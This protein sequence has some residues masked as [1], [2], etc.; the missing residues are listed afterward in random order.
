MMNELQTYM[1]YEYVA[2]YRAGYLS[3]RDLVRRVLNI[4]GGVGS[5]ATLLLTLGCS[6]QPAAPTSAPAA[7]TTAPTK[8]AAASP[9]PS[10]VGASSPAARPAATAPSPSAAAKPA[11][12]PAP[13]A[14]ASP[15][16]VARSPLAVTANDPTVDGQDISF[17]GADGATILAYQA[18][19][20][21]ASGPLPLVLVCHENRGLTEHI[22]DVVR[23]FTKEGYLASGVDLVSRQ[24]GTAR[25]TDP[26]QFSALLTGPNVNPDQFVSDFASA[27]AY[28]KTR[29]DL[30]QFDKI[31][32]N[33]YC[34]GGGVVWRSTE[35]IMELEAA[36][37][38]YG[39]FPPPEKWN[40]IKAAVLGVYSSDPNDFANNR[41]D[42]LD[43]ALTAS[44]DVHKFN[45]YPGTMHAFHND[46]GPTY[47]EEQ[48]L[49]A[50]RDM[51][52]W[53]KQYLA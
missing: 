36:A 19:P 4:T 9:A 29:P 23:R 53:F 35:Q 1:V 44:G 47:N 42:E 33:G 5:T 31:A 37:P 6:A 41:R 38:F 17:P 45:V 10:P 20:R 30:V 11:A 8:P 39:A 16:P 18:R 46:T 43:Q 24:G 2:D 15:S 26:N 48:A 7:A 22:R 32:M 28:Y 40:Q 51:I 25:I 49:A 3:R 14:V 27:V 12:S 52:A 21:S 50:W 13:S 34:F